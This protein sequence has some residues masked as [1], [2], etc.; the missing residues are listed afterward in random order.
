MKKYIK[1][2]IYLLLFLTLSLAILVIDYI[3]NSNTPEI[4]DDINSGVIGVILTTC[5]TLLLLSNQSENEEN[6]T[7]KS[8]VYEE[9]LKAFNVFINTFGQ[10]L[11]DGKLTL[12]DT[13]KIIHSL[14]LLRIHISQGNFVR[15]ENS[16]STIDDSFFYCDENSI[17]DLFKLSKLYTEITS[18]LRLELYGKDDVGNLKIFEYENFRK[19]LYR[20]RG[21]KIIFPTFDDFIV[22]LQKYSKIYSESKKT[23]L[24]IVYELTPS[25]IEA[26]RTF[27]DFI[28]TIVD[29]LEVD[30]L[31]YKQTLSPNHT[32]LALISFA[33]ELKTFGINTEI[34]SGTPLVRLYVQGHYFAW[35]GLTEMKKLSVYSMIPKSEVIATLEIYEIDSIEK[36]KLTVFKGL[37]KAIK[38]I[39]PKIFLESEIG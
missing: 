16:I 34:F 28:A 35:F 10:C 15:L 3:N 39:E 21:Y 19:I 20:K 14:S 17:P 32:D 9:K 27:H 6:L 26:I 30:L 33:F 12:E 37:H 13:R 4:V 5:I 25:I 1:F 11:E 36:F 7:R 38:S 29:D 18:V 2:L 22:E 24:T 23:G 8:V 31:L